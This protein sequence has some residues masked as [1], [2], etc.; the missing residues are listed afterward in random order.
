MRLLN[1]ID[2]T[3]EEFIGDQVPAY[4]I[5]SHRWTNQEVSYQDFLNDRST[6][7]QGFRQSYGWTKI[8]KARAIAKVRGYRW[9]WLDSCCI[10]K[11]SS[12]ELTEAINSMFNWYRRSAECYV[13]LPDVHYSKVAQAAETQWRSGSDPYFG[14]GAEFDDTQLRSSVWFTRSWTLQELLAPRHVYFFDS[15]FT[16]FASKDSHSS[17]FSDITGIPA[18]FLSAT[19]GNLPF[20]VAKASIGERLR[21]ASQRQATRKEDISY[22]LLGIFEIN[23]PLLY[24]EEERSFLRLQTEIIRKSNDETI[25]VWLKSNPEGEGILAPD[26]SAFSKCSKILSAPHVQRQHYEVTHKG[27]QVLLPLSIPELTMKFGTRG[28]LKMLWKLNCSVDVGSFDVR[29]RRMVFILARLQP[30]QAFDLQSSRSKQFHFLLAERIGLEFL[31]LDEVRKLQYRSAETRPD[32]VV[33]GIDKE[34]RGH[35]ADIEVPI[36]VYFKTGW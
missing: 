8:L 9:F 7:I 28:E 5:I 6:I 32:I 17:L 2:L 22:S 11:K 21:W 23:M 16:C 18:M 3:F 34:V 30:E 4:A 35:E 10:D 31:T 14:Y 26:I 25:F 12:A 24:G 15:D 33:A 36:P 19:S 20:D 1:V 29:L 27:L 13:F